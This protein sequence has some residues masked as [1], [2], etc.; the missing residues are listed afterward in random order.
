MFVHI[1]VPHTQGF[2]TQILGDSRI[3]DLKINTEIKICAVQE[4]EVGRSS[5]LQSRALSI[6]HESLVFDTQ[7]G[8]KF[9]P[10]PKQVGCLGDKKLGIRANRALTGL[11][12]ALKLVAG[13]VPPQCSAQLAYAGGRGPKTTPKKNKKEIKS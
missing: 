9:M 8:Y 6:T 5:L 11:R 13:L 1:N 2:C 4:Q 12:G 7:G 3:G 10:E